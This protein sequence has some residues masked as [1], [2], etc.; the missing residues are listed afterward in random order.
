M[1]RKP[2][3]KLIPICVGGY[4]KNDKT[5]NGD[6]SATGAAAL[7]CTWRRRCTGFKAHLRQSNVDEDAY[8]TI[9]KIKSPSL[10][11]KLGWSTT[12]EPIGK[13]HKEFV[14]WCESLAAE[15]GV[16]LKRGYKPNRKLSPTFKENKQ[17]SKRLIR[18]FV[19]AFRDS[20]GAQ[21]SLRK[22]GGELI[23]PGMYYISDKKRTSG[24]LALYRRRNSAERTDVAI[25]VC[26][27]KPQSRALEVRLGVD[28]R[29]LQD[30]MG[31]RWTFQFKPEP[32]NDGQFVTA[33]KNLDEDSAMELA[34]AIGNALKQGILYL[35]RQ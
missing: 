17:E 6:R 1:P 14:E 27:L 3:Q 20:S 11:K 35:P 19:V 25:F 2:N 29:T 8:V 18:Q 28:M 21:F 33:I 9:V 24:Y 23:M 26:Y 34:E 30:A 31:N 15:H 7:P 32:C 12:A 13:D 4:D 22:R 10:R 16:N 5:C